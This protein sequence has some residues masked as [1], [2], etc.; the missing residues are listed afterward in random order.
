MSAPLRHF[1]IEAGPGDALTVWMDVAGK[2]VN[3]FWDEVLAELDSLIA[4]WE[5]GAHHSPAIIRSA[6]SKG[7]CA[8]ADLKRIAAFQSADEVEAFLRQGQ[9]VF[10]R[11]ERLRRPTVAVIH[12]HCLGGGLEFAL[13]CRH[14]VA[15]KQPVAGPTQ[16]GLPETTLGLIPAWGGTQRLPRLVGLAT[17][18]DLMCSGE[19]LGAD[20]ARQL[21][22]V[23]AVLRGPDVE[24][25]LEAWIAMLAIDPPDPF[26]APPFRD[27]DVYAV[28]EKRW[29]SPDQPARQAVMEA[30]RA[31]WRRD[32][33]AGLDAERSEFLERVFSD[34]CRRRLEAMFHRK[35]P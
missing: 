31:G 23:D 13:A 19:S 14:R 12:G 22:L 27:A 6:K 28:A 25:E 11:L 29:L 24:S 20:E 33:Q 3:I 32:M 4:D 16:L 15:V 1:R 21:G 10:G 35:A 9:Q 26:V 2:P 30:V 5:R 34:D 7:F 18:L 17:A 8:G